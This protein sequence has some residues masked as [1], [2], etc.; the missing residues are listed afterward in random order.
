MPPPNPIPTTT[1]IGDFKIIGPDGTPIQ[2]VQVTVPGPD[3][4]P[5]QVMQIQSMTK[6][7]MPST[8]SQ[9]VYRTPPP[10]PA[11]PPPTLSNFPQRPTSA[12]TTEASTPETAE[13]K[14]VPIGFKEHSSETNHR[15]IS[16][17]TAE[18]NPPLQYPTQNDKNVSILCI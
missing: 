4:K 3:G 11:Y 9:P 12:A 5:M 13:R 8:Q 10:P 16:L 14:F 15:S 7:S 6:V 2:L 18:C 17:E 1:G